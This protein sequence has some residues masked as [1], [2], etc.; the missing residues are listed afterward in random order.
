MKRLGESLQVK[1]LLEDIQSLSSNRTIESTAVNDWRNFDP[2]YLHLA[3]LIERGDGRTLKINYPACTCAEGYNMIR[4]DNKPNATRCENCYDLR[5]TLKRILLAELPNDSIDAA[6]ND[7]RF[8]SDEHKSI[9]HHMK[10]YRRGMLPPCF[11]MHGSAGNGKTMLLYIIAKHCAANG[12]RIKYAHHYHTFERHKKSWNDPNLRNKNYL[13]EFLKGVDVLLLDEFGG[14]GGGIDQHSSWFKNTTIEF[15]GTIYEKFKS[16]Q[17]SVVM[18]SNI[19]P[20]DIV[21]KVLNN[22]YSAVSRIKSMFGEPIEL[23]ANDQRQRFDNV[24]G[25]N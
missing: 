13:D 8:E 21:K 22:N 15:L 17:L 6:L 5:K 18:T 25:W 12:F 3:G 4:L 7:Y 1:K 9:F 2:D 11:F 20:N 10:N 23:R 24:V 19:K 14:L 16:N